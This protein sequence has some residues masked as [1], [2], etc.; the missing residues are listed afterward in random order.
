MPSFAGRV[1][2]ALLAAPAAWAGNVNIDTSKAQAAKTVD[3][4]AARF[5]YPPPVHRR[6]TVGTLRPKY[7]RKHPNPQRPGRE[8][9]SRHSVQ[10]GRRAITCSERKDA[11]VSRHQAAR[12]RWTLV[13]VIAVLAAACGH[14]SA[15]PTRTTPITNTSV[16]SSAPTPTTVG[17]AWPSS[18]LRRRQRA[19]R[20]RPPRRLNHRRVEQ[21]ILVDAAP[22]KRRRPEAARTARRRSPTSKAAS[23]AKAAAPSP[24]T[25]SHCQPA[26]PNSPPTAETCGEAMSCMPDQAEDW[27]ATVAIS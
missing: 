3:S 18:A 4:L 2:P 25:T 21:H 27:R 22:D 26:N 11:W 9:Q 15:A 5:T 13:A 17:G 24:P 14:T 16:A 23:Q 20:Q 19:N 1:A 8:P 6:P 7:C 12:G 10:S